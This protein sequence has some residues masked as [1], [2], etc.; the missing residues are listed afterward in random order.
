[1]KA[2]KKRDDGIEIAL[3]VQPG[4]RR[5]GIVGLHGDAVKLAVRA[6]A[7]EGEANRAVVEALAE[8]F[9]VPKR[10]VEITSGH[11]S[12]A[13]RVRVRG[14]PEALARTL[15]SLLPKEAR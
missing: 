9:G 11:A 6:R 2:V 10:A 7:K 3:H 5:E 13:K 4:A 14:E 1:M 8:I 15:A 12:R